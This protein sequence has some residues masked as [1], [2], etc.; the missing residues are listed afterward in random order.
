[1]E[2]IELFQGMIGFQGVV[3]HCSSLII[4]IYHCG[5]T[6]AE[7]GPESSDFLMTYLNHPEANTLRL[8]VYSLR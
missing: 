1:M 6:A 7:F 2:E 3:K 5:R 4:N 8:T